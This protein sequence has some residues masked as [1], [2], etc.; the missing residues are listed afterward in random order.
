MY[1]SKKDLLN[2]LYQTLTQE[3]NKEP[4]VWGKKALLSSQQKTDYN[5]GERGMKMKN[6]LCA[7]TKIKYNIIKI[8]IIN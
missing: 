7:S 5:C 2:P 4:S 8:I 1:E 6:F 3:M